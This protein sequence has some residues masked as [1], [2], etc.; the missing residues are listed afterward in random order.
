MRLCG[1]WRIDATTRRVAIAA[2]LLAVHVT[3]AAAQ[4]SSAVY[5]AAR[6]MEP[7]RASDRFSDEI[8]VLEVVLPV[9]VLLR[10]EPLAGLEAE[11]F[12]IWQDDR[13]LPILGIE[14]VDLRRTEAVQDGRRRSSGAATESQPPP[15]GERSFLALFDLA[16]SPA[17]RL[18]LA[19][20]S[21]RSM[22]ETQLHPGDRVGVA[23]LGGGGSSLLVPL[24]LDRERVAA[25]LD[26]VAAMTSGR[27][28]RVAEARERLRRLP[29]EGLR[30]LA[31]AVGP[32]AALTF[33]SG[34]ISGT[35]ADPTL[36]TSLGGS[37]PALGA[38]D[39]GSG[40]PLAIAAELEG[41]SQLSGRR[42]LGRYVEELAVL[43]S[44]VPGD[45]CLM[46]FA[47]GI[48]DFE[49]AVQAPLLGSGL[50]DTY[51]SMVA[52][53][54][55]SG[56]VLN[57]FDV[58]GV[59][60]G[61]AGSLF[62]LADETG[63]ELFDD[64]GHLEV[65]TQR[66]VERTSVS[67]RLAFR[68]PELVADGRFRPVE[69]RLRGVPDGAVV[70]GS[71]GYSAPRPNADK[72][73]LE[74]RLEDFERGLRADDRA[75][76]PARVTLLT[77]PIAPGTPRAD[78][79]ESAGG[80]GD[81]GRRRV[82]LMLEVDGEALLGALPAGALDRRFALEIMASAADGRVSRYQPGAVVDL[83]RER[84]ELRQ[85]SDRARLRDGLRFLGDLEVGSGEHEV[86]VRLREARGGATFHTTRIVPAMTTHQAE[87]GSLVAYLVAPR[88]R[89]ILAREGDTEAH[90]AVGSPL[91]VADEL[92]LPAV[93]RRFVRG[94]EG[95]LVLRFYGVDP[96]QVRLVTE[97][98]SE[99]D[100]ELATAL[101]L[102]SGASRRDES[103][104]SVVVATSL[105]T[106]DL[107]PGSY[108]LL[109]SWFDGGGL[110]GAAGVE[111]DVL[112]APAP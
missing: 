83:L 44:G 66:L 58:M 75:D 109:I 74:R 84:I 88:G 92:L 71:L 63:G 90:T 32:A 99:D 33:A 73:R 76:F 82:T 41:F 47:A 77:T 100:R 21:M 13:K 37:N 16:Q 52:A 112:A 91:R 12:E 59:G 107:A 81:R 22:V 86:R 35:L 85:E 72:S 61:S 34:E 49:S 31:A 40:D 97:L 10:G 103:D 80:T 65:A 108:R 8:T 106:A 25:G 45:K 38:I 89:G 9:R 67:Y 70:H 1:R 29:G 27:A 110:Q 19:V 11:N 69:V 23:V 93:R 26:L 28:R 30:E 42:R 5:D 50:L 20:D 46:Y 57:A 36:T 104:G 95:L 39:S 56:W 17:N 51:V 2:V 48:P 18:R 96:N 53:L 111:F 6:P 105:E 64:Y 78:E 98:R 3:A 14:R 24:T 101:D 87:V 43:L 68:T 79:S 60:E 62:Y 102:W 55:R 4:P 7:E 15:L 54:V 94:E